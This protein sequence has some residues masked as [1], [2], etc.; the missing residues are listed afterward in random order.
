MATI[1]DVARLADVSVATVSRVLNG[2]YPVSEEKK[3]AVQRA[4]KELNFT[5][6]L[7]GRNLGRSHNRTI[8]VALNAMSGT[9]MGESLQGVND[10]AAERGYDVLMTYLPSDRDKPSA[11][12]WQRCVEYLQGGFA[13]GAILLGPVATDSIPLEQL[14]DIPVVRCGEGVFHMG[15]NC[16]T[17]DNALAAYDLTK[18]LISKGCRRFAFVLSQKPAETEPSDYSQARERGMRRALEEAGL[19]FRP[20]WSLVCRQET[21]AQDTSYTAALE[22]M[23]FFTQLPPD[24]RPDAIICTF[25]VLALAC[26]HTLQQAGIRVPEEIAVAGFDDSAAATYCNPG[27]TSVRQ[28]SRQMSQEA[29]RILIELMEG[30]R[31]NGVRVLLPHSITERGSTDVHRD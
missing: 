20:E 1:R 23:R 19:P 13:G 18:R 2:N 5:P 17:Y 22:S 10:V 25:D 31:Q 26:V 7:I 3:K 12:S 30:K 29:T 4:V 24:Q 16:V 21:S 11:F 9:L 27:I 6:N 28:P 14:R 15:G 8:L